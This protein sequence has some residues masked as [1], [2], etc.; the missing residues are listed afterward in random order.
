MVSTGTEGQ[1]PQ[2]VIVR[3]HRDVGELVA[4]LAAFQ[5][6]DRVDALLSQGGRHMSPTEVAER[7]AQVSEAARALLVHFG[8]NGSNAIASQHATVM[9]RSRHLVLGIL[10]EIQGIARA[11]PAETLTPAELQERQL[12]M[13]NAYI[14]FAREHSTYWREKLPAEPLTRPEDVLKLPVTTKADIMQFHTGPLVADIQAGKSPLEIQTPMMTMPLA[15]LELWKTSASS[16]VATVTVRT[17]EEMQA[18]NNDIGRFLRRW[19]GPGDRIGNFMHAGSGWSGSIA[20]RESLNFMGVVTEFLG[21]S[22]EPAALVADWQRFGFN[23]VFVNPSWLARFLTTL[24]TTPNL[25]YLLDAIPPIEKFPFGG[26]PPSATV[27]THDGRSIPL[28]TYL[29]ERWNTTLISV[30]SGTEIGLV[31]IPM[32]PQQRQAIHFTAMD[33]LALIEMINESGAPA[34][35]GDEAELVVTRFTNIAVPLVRFASG[36]GVVLLN[37]STAE[38]KGSRVFSFSKKGTR[39]DDT[40]IIE[41]AKIFNG[42][43]VATAVGER[44][45]TIAQ[46]II[47]DRQ[48]EP[49]TLITIRTERPLSDTEKP[50]AEQLVREK[51]YEIES[52]DEVRELLG[53]TVFAFGS[54]CE[55]TSSGKMR[56]VL[57]RRG[58]AGPAGATSGK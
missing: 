35:K 28:P 11:Y 49:G 42:T 26:E 38:G 54:P 17:P 33:D 1:N 13:L 19:V 18:S 50:L 52:S 23:G 7:L 16:G 46:I 34:G 45:L 2:D 15:G 27:T 56:P 6:A 43:R 14:R 58:Q 29:R 20:V 32:T 22:D 39:T 25:R 37:E 51:I 31:G 24:E 41:N 9:D 48:G 10:G 12:K 55:K 44:F 5:R 30:Y 4:M 53:R 47:Q 36:D 8:V 3:A 21:N 57:N 40:L